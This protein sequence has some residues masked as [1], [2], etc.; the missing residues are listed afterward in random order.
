MKR[1]SQNTHLQLYNE[2]TYRGLPVNLNHGPLIEEYLDA[3]HDVVEAALRANRRVFAFRVDLHLPA[4][5]CDEHGLY[6]NN[7]VRRFIES[8]KAQIK[9]NRM[10]AKR[11]RPTAAGTAVRYMW[12]REQ[13]NSEHP[14]WHLVILLNFDA[15]RSIGQFRLGNDNMYSRVVKAWASALQLPVT[16]AEGLVHFPDKPAYELYRDDEASLQPFFHRAS[17]LCK[18]ETKRYGDRQRGFAYSRS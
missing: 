10:L 9:H 15:F 17:Y 11:E 1:F 16:E 13:R 7:I 12:V 2:R 5:C 8:L 18:A 4:D 6:D 14:H 3:L